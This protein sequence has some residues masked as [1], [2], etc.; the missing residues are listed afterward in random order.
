MNDLT[1]HIAL[2]D[3]VLLITM[4]RALIVVARWAIRKLVLYVLSVANELEDH[5]VDRE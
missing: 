2:A 5:N 1:I 3:L 4:V